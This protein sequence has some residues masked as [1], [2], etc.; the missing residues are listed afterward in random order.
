M[1]ISFTAEWDHFGSSKMEIASHNLFPLAKRKQFVRP[2]IFFSISSPVHLK[3]F[4]YMIYDGSGGRTPTKMCILSIRCTSL[5]LQ[6][7]YLHTK[8]VVIYILYHLHQMFTIL[9]YNL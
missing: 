4:S 8:D 7:Q 6:Y 2:A 5:D 3:P 1:F 9:L